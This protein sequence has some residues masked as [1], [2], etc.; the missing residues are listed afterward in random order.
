MTRGRIA[1]WSQAYVGLPYGQADCGALVERVQHEVFAR[2]VVIPS[3]RAE[4]TRALVEQLER[5]I[6]HMLTDQLTATDAPVDGDVVHMRA[7]PSLRHVGL[8]CEMGRTPHVLHALRGA[9]QTVIHRLREL[10]RHNLS[11][12]GYYTWLI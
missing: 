11:V 1:H 9:R 5:T 6:R 7:G 10:H 8:Y 3:E 2:P 4:G 12:L